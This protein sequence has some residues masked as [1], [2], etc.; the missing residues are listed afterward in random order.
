MESRFDGSFW[1][2]AV[3]PFASD[4]RRTLLG[5]SNKYWTLSV[6]FLTNTLI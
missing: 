1:P 2:I 5:L 4:R 3:G 6:A